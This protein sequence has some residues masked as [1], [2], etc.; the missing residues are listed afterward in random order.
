M[1]KYIMGIEL[2]QSLADLHGGRGGYWEDRGYEWYA[3]I[4]SASSS[5]K[6]GS[7]K[8]PTAVNNIGAKR[9]FQTSAAFGAGV[10]GD[11]NDLEFS[12]GCTDHIPDS[13]AHQKPRHW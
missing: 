6:R 13:F 9:I 2:G 12:T 5:P 11:C 3:G 4:S 1:A 8:G 10:L 7:L